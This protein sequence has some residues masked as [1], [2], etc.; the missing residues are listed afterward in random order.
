MV[1]AIAKYHMTETMRKVLI[2]SMDVTGGRG[3]QEGPRNVLATAYKATP[4][5]ITV[6]GAN[7]L[8]RNL[9]IFGQGAIR[10]HE[11]VFPEMEAARENDLAAFDK[12]LY[13]HIGFSVNRAVRAFTHGI[14]GSRLARAPVNG[15]LAHYFRQ[16]ERMS[17]ALAFCSDTTMGVLGGKLKFMERMSARLGDVLSQ[18]YIASAVIK[19]YLE[20]GQQE[21][22]RDLARWALDN[23]L[24]EIGKAFTEF[25][26]N[27]PVR[28]AAWVMRRVVFP[29]GNPYRP[30]SDRLN[31]KVAEQLLEQTAVRERL[32]WL[33]FKNG[34]P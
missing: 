13:G 10:C 20:G 14:S 31:A 12:L 25:L 27:F 9:M 29:L 23:C 18:L 16:M 4:V 30:V 24:Y 21:D 26:E 28:P 7:I 15:P 1:T 34:G 17:S 6:E 8:T 2:D 3:I 32:T 19:F 5:A 22:E 11:Y 33:V